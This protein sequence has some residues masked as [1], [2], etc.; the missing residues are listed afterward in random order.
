MKPWETIDAFLKAKGVKIGAPTKGQTDGGKHSPTSAHPQGRGRDYGSVGSDRGAV[1][2]ELLPYAKRGGP[3][4]ELFYSGTNTFW[5][6]SVE[7]T[8]SADLRSTHWDH[9]H[10]ALWPGRTMPTVGIQ[11]S[12]IEMAEQDKTTAA[13]MAPSGR[14]CWVLDRDGGVRAYNFDEKNPIPHHGSLFDYPK[15]QA[16]KGRY[17]IAIEPIGHLVASPQGPVM[18]YD[19]S[20]GYW[21]IANDGFRGKFV[22]K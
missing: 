12:E 5:D 8:P 3:V 18:T 4:M 9:V 1:V 16:V 21:I 14:G 7:F 10:V 13:C 20:F 22:K 19:D 6:N 2:R 15:E 11:P 17:F